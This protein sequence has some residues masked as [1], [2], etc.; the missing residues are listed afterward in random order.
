MKPLCVRVLGHSV[1]ISVYF[2]VSLCVLLLADRSGTL[3]WGL[4]AAVLH[5]CGHLLAMRWVLH[6]VCE[7]HLT[8]FGM[9]LHRRA[10]QTPSY[11]AEC[12][13]ALAGPLVNL[14]V[15]TI[16]M[17]L[18]CTVP[19]DAIATQYAL[20][21][22]NLLPI[23][24]LDG[25]QALRALCGRLLSPVATERVSVAVTFFCLL[26]LT[27]VVFLQV[28]QQQYNFSLLAIAVYLVIF[29]VQTVR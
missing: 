8:A 5:E 18:P 9:Q 11:G 14:V 16:L 23:D 22:F 20:G 26:L 25:G 2:C 19:R 17:V 1:T 12:I 4:C 28:L 3:C 6:Q 21:L 29:F 13:C 24:P 7:V 27:S 15:G 10:L